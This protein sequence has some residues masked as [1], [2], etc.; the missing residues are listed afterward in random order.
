MNEEFAFELSNI[1]QPHQILSNEKDIRRETR[2]VTSDSV[3]VPLILY[4]KS[5][6]EVQQVI[7]LANRFKVQL[8]P[9]STGKNWGLGSKLPSG[10][11][12]V[13]LDLHRMNRII[14]VNEEFGYAIIEP[15]VTQ[16]QLFEHL[17]AT[18]SAFMSD[19][20]GSG[21]DTSLLGNALDKG[22]GY[23]LL[24]YEQLLN[25]EVVLGN[26][27]VFKTGF[28]HYEDCKATFVFPD[29][30]GPSYLKMF[31]QSNF[32]VVTRAAIALKRRPERNCMFLT[33]LKNAD[34]LGQAIGEIK[35][36]KQQGLVRSTTHY[37]EN[38][39]AQNGLAPVMHQVLKA[40]GHAVDREQIMSF[41]DR[42][43]FGHGVI[44]S[45]ISGT[46]LQIAAAKK[47]LKALRP[48]GIT[49]Y[50]TDRLM[51]L[52]LAATRLL[53]MN[54]MH[55]YVKAGDGFYR[56]CLGE[57]SDRPLMS[58][59][60]PTQTDL[61]DDWNNPDQ[62]NIGMNFIVPTVPMSPDL[63]QQATAIIRDVNKSYRSVQASYS[64]GLR[65]DKCC[66]FSVST[67][68]DRTEEDS[69]EES[70]SLAEELNRKFIENGFH[71]NRLHVSM[72]GLVVDPD[73]IF[74]QLTRDI[75]RIVDP[76]NTIAP[77]HYNIA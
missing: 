40:M 27:K 44:F 65:D 17:N 9:Y 33:F 31:L 70:R 19:T 45:N 29:G 54:K 28:G 50:V 16:F 7:V 6:D 34:H 13:I 77:G 20:T 36:L 66:D 21:K 61:P 4:P 23:N 72:M 52:G 35:T 73:D 63:V 46:R 55:A 53:K 37:Y 47:G 64:F 8:Q 67:H 18:G 3:E 49:V 32:G 48:F 68:F 24:R 56:M 69:A 1:M 42:W 11:G 43:S 25:L 75:K 74:W 62:T 10:D 59:Y 30:I 71:P 76:H 41:L 58:L 12:L 38:V 60:W 22:V 39:R 26:G 57:P 5:A 2:N 14:E 51:R 15:G